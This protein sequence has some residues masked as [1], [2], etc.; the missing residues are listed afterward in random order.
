[1]RPQQHATKAVLSVNETKHEISVE[2]AIVTA[3]CRKNSPEMPGMNAEGTKTAQ[4]VNAIA[5][6]APPTSSIVLRAA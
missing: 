2:A 6:S 1:M 4:S 5:I 3:N